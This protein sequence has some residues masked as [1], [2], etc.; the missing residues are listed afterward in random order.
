MGVLL[1]PALR[2]VATLRPSPRVVGMTVGTSDFV[3]TGDSIVGRLDDP[4]K[5]LHLMEHAE[6]ATFLRRAVVCE[7][8]DD[9]LIQPAETAQA[10][11]EAADLV[12]GVVEERGER[13]LR[14]MGHSG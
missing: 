11:Y 2:G 7:D 6:R 10:V 5:E 8:D 3:Q 9:R 4:V 1:V 12:V 14:S 13:L